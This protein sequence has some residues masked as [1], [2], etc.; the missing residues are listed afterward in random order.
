MTASWR[1]LSF[2]QDWLPSLP[3][4]SFYSFFRTR[5]HLSFIHPSLSWDSVDSTGGHEHGKP[6]AIEIVDL[7][8]I[9]VK[10]KKTINQSNK[11]LQRWEGKGS[12][13]LGMPKHIYV[14]N[15]TMKKINQAGCTAEA[16][17]SSGG[18]RIGS[19]EWTCSPWNVPSCFFREILA[20]CDHFRDKYTAHTWQY[21]SSLL[22]SEETS[23]QTCK[24]RRMYVWHPYLHVL[25]SL[26]MKCVACFAVFQSSWRFEVARVPCVL[27]PAAGGDCKPPS[28][29]A[30]GVIALPAP[31]FTRWA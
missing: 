4:Q 2:L 26:L 3:Y 21:H 25:G 29:Q 14:K 27:F 15:K 10:K 11:T 31:V 24:R 23:S 16:D 6:G 22:L 30:D 13:P 28:T 20:D 8:D 7:Q 5:C 18:W 17:T 19:D 12:R 1:P 9:I